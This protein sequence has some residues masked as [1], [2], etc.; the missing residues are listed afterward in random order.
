ME[1]LY[2]IYHRSVYAIYSSLG[3]IDCRLYILDYC[4]LSH[5]LNLNLIQLHYFKHLEAGDNSDR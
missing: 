2:Y 3:I 5:D 4:M 1:K